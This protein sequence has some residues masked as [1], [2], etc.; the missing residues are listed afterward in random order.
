MS[1]APD[2]TLKIISH[3]AH[4]RSRSLEYFE[5]DVSY[6]HGHFNVALLESGL[7]FSMCVQPSASAGDDDAKANNIGPQSDGMKV[8]YD[9][10]DFHHHRISWILWY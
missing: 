9:H 7:F 10:Q 8:Q 2:C 5:N 6:F 4:A 3:Y 1:R